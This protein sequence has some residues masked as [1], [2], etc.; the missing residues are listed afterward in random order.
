MSLQ[1]SSPAEVPSQTAA[2]DRVAF[3]RGNAYIRLKDD[4]GTLFTDA[5]VLLLRPPGRGTL[6]AG[7]R[8]LVAVFREP[9][10]PPRGRIDWKYLLG[11]DLT[12]PGFDASV[13]SEFRFRLVSGH[14]ETLL[15]TPA[16]SALPS[17]PSLTRSPERAADGAGT[18]LEIA[19][20]VVRIGA[21]ASEAQNR[22]VIQALRPRP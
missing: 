6:A 13:L 22:A 14:A 11:L 1:P 16:A 7:A 17:V 21:H 15:T 3:P 4:L 12:D 2:V 20:V 9:L 5:H 19:G 18:E 8:Y 10:G